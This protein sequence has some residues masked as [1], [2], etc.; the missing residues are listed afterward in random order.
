MPLTLPVAEL[1]VQRAY[2]TTTKSFKP[3]L[4]FQEKEQK[5]KGWLHLQDIDKFQGLGVF[6]RGRGDS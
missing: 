4:L 6:L 5:E 2:F 1:E 3:V